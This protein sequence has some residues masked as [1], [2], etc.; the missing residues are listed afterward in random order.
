MRILKLGASG[1]DVMKMQAILSKTGYYFGV[2][3]VVN[4]NVNYT[5]EIMVKDIEELVARYSFIE[6]GIA[7]ES[8]L[9]KSLYYIKLGRG[10]R[11]MAIT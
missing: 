7:G 9:G 11:S 3:D 8:V 6:T 10:P 1:S 5:Y 4:T 2:I